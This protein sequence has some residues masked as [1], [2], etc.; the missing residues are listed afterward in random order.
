MIVS[1]D[2]GALGARCDGD[3]VNFALYSAH[4]DAVE[5]C[6]FDASGHETARLGLPGHADGVWHGYVPGCAA[7]QRYGY[8]V[9]GPYDPANGQRFNPYKLLLDPYARALSGTFQWR[10][11]VFAYQSERPDDVAALSTSDSAPFVPKSVVVSE[12]IKAK[13]GVRIP[14]AESLVYETHVRGFTMRHPAVAA[15]DRGKFRGLRN[16]DVLRYLKALGVTTIELMPVHA[17]LDEQFLVARGLRNF[18]GYNTIAFFA[19]EPRYSHSDGVAEFREMIEA[20]HDSGFE[21]VLDVVYNHTAEGNSLGPTLSFRGID[22]T[23]YY[24]LVPD[25]RSQYINATGC[26]NTIDMENAAVRRLVLDSLR[27]WVGEMSVDGFRFDLATIL[28]RAASGFERDHVFFRELENDPSLAGVKLIAE[29]WDVGLGGYQLGQFPAGWAEWNDRYRDSIRQFWRG[30]SGSAGE[31]AHR[32]LGSAD[33]FEHSGRGPWASINFAASHDGFTTADL[34]SFE[35]RHN[36]DNGEASRDGHEHNYSANYGIEGPCDDATIN[37]IRRRQR[38]N[39]LATVLLSEGTP[40]LLAGDELGNSQAGNNNAYAQDNDVGWIDWSGLETDPDFLAQIQSVIRLRQRLTL[41]RKAT[42]LH[43][44]T[45]NANGFAD[46]EWLGADGQPMMT[47]AW[48]TVTALTVL[49]CDTRM[50]PFASHEVQAVA[51][52]F[53]VDECVRVLQLPQVGRRG[54]WHVVY[55]TAAISS[56]EVIAQKIEL[57]ARNLI[58]LVYAE[59]MPEGLGA[60]AT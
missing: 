32:Y 45:F 10:P 4:A 9:H 30:D 13:A 23:T 14:W 53:N 11:E 43:G 28:G 55:S 40:M 56:R 39:L 20:L 31:F 47:E 50:R 21:V 7:G 58:C 46:I 22:N 12:V 48:R 6:L 29:P 42:Y 17:F 38:L 5:L 59:R 1:G 24:R 49:L 8:R 51:V 34:V 44:Q 57:Q 25:D 16:A 52:L 33:N 2:H 41:L 54:A 27:Y 37:A 3:G 15:A 35:H 18:W 26:G 19:P 36:E 60:T